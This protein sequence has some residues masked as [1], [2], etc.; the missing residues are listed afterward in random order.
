MAQP[1]PVA[2]FI[3]QDGRAQVTCTFEAQSSGSGTSDWS[4]SVN[5]YFII[6]TE[7]LAGGGTV[8]TSSTPKGVTTTRAKY[9]EM[10]SVAVSAG[11]TVSGALSLSTS[12]GPSVTAWNID[13][14]MELI[15]R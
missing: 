12:V 6:I 5:G 7:T 4:S 3:E 11:S 10:L 15:K 9:T 2:L 8:T 14:R 13:T 1:Q